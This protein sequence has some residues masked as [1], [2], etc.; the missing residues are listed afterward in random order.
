MWLPRH[1]EFLAFLDV[2]MADG[3]TKPSVR[4]PT[5]DRVLSEIRSHS[6]LC[7]VIRAYLAAREVAA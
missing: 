3:G 5:A 7:G 2:D 4:G 6:D 1:G